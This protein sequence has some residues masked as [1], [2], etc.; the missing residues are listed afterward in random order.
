MRIRQASACSVPDT[1]LHA[2]DSEPTI[3][4]AAC[5]L[6]ASLCSCAR[7][8]QPRPSATHKVYESWAQFMAD[9]EDRKI[10]LLIE[11]NCPLH[12]TFRLGR[13]VE[14]GI[15]LRTF[16]I[17]EHVAADVL[18]KDG[19][20]ITSAGVRRGVILKVRSISLLPGSRG[21]L[22]VALSIL[23]VACAVH[24][25][26]HRDWSTALFAGSAVLILSSAIAGMLT[27]PQ[28]WPIGQ[29]ESAEFFRQVNW[30][31]LRAFSWLSSLGYVLAGAGGIV[32][33]VSSQTASTTMRHAAE[34]GTRAGAQA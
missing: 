21:L 23:V 30:S 25:K 18:S 26:R 7:R 28:A 24:W 11:G 27:A 32:S 22:A 5:I 14:G 29:A 31:L 9:V 15:V 16:E 13:V 1:I 17:P 3:F 33:I 6:L 8:Q 12:G 2:S 34:E 20:K 10:D 19:G 4:P